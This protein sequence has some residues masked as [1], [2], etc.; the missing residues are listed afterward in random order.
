MTHVCYEKEVP[1]LNQIHD[2]ENSWL[3][4]KQTYALVYVRN[5]NVSN[6]LR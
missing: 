1:I 6:V 5:V 4:W 3:P 2:Y